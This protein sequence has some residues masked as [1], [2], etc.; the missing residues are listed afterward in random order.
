MIHD[1]TPWWNTPD[2]FDAETERL[3]DNG[4]KKEPL[5]LL[6]EDKEHEMEEKA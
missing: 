5:A 6:E 2:D 3:M 1:D 4:T